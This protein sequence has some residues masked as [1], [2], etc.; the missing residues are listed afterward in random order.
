MIHAVCWEVCSLSP[1]FPPFARFHT[2][3]V[4]RIFFFHM[5]GVS[6]I[7]LSKKR[8]SFLHIQTN[9][10]QSFKVNTFRV[11]KL[12]DQLGNTEKY[13]PMWDYS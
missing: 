9:I 6:R 4:S 2:E 12:I 3:G 5:E 11:L 8:S 13:A 1:G 10:E 7:F